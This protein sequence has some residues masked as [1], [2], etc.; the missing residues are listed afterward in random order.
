MTLHDSDLATGP[1][2]YAL[3]RQLFPICRAT[4][5][6]G[7]RESLRQLQAHIPL[8]IHEVSTG[9][10]VFDWEVPQEWSI[11]DAFIKDPKGRR[12]VDFRE[13]NL[14]VVSGSVPVHKKMKWSDLKGHLHSLPEQ[15][16]LVPYRTSFYSG[17]WGFSLTHA[18]LEALA[19]GGEDADYEVC[20]ESEFKDG[21]L[22]YGELLIPGES[23]DEVLLSTHVC[24]PSLAND[25]LSGITV[26]TWLGKWL[27]E[28]PRRYSYRILF[29]PATIGAITWLSLNEHRVTNIKY[30]LVLALLGDAGGLT[31]KQSRQSAARIDRIA[32][33]ILSHSGEPH[34]LRAFEPFGYDQRQFCSPGFDLPV[35]CL[36]RTPN[37]EFPAYH[38][39]ADNLAFIHPRQLEKSLDTCK[40]IILGIEADR[41]YINR[42]PKCEPRLGKHGLYEA[43]GASIDRVRLQQAVQWVLN[44]SCGMNSLLDIAERSGMPLAELRDV[45]TRLA[46]CGLLDE[47]GIGK[48][49]LNEAQIDSRCENTA[50]GFRRSLNSST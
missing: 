20:I 9:T 3:A 45:A 12:V 24:H 8:E 37:G 49:Q 26:A 41:T 28:T 1:E 6:P 32:A 4:T 48:Q 15:P 42:N 43:F 36:M 44:L 7:V 13:S 40:R 10:K 18:Q 5:G 11:A 38:T 23:E 25:N 19:A 22:S 30:G 17:T 50:L 46:Q 39:S 2:M 21:S 16:N 29:V 34:E 35:G 14:H 33:H 31:Y 47:I 27:S